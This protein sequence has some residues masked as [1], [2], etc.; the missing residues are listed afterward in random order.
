[1]TTNTETVSK[2][3]ADIRAEYRFSEADTVQNPGC[4]EAEHVSTVYFEHVGQEGSDET[5][6]FPEGSIDV[7]LVSAAERALLGLGDDV[8]YFALTVS[9][10]GFYSGETWTEEEYATVSAR[11]AGAAEEESQD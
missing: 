3:L 10:Q 1:M 7:F 4:F 11:A 2:I 8:R 5:I 9:D 6:D